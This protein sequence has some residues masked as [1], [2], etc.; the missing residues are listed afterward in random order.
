[1]KPKYYVFGHVTGSSNCAPISD[2]RVIYSESA[3]HEDDFSTFII[4]HTMN[5]KE[6]MNILT[7]L[8]FQSP[9]AAKLLEISKKPY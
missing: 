8:N 9:L 4:S 3:H 2:K 6:F 5:T 1:M 7:F